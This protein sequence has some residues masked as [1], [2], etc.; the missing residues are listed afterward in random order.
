MHIKSHAVPTFIVATSLLVGFGSATS[1]LSA[2][3]TATRSAQSPGDKRGNHNLTFIPEKYLKAYQLQAHSIRHHG[4][5]WLKRSTGSECNPIYLSD[6]ASR[7]IL[8]YD[9][10]PPYQQIGSLTSSGGYG[11]G[12][13]AN[14][15]AIF[16]GNA[17]VD[18]I[19]EYAPCGA[20]VGLHLAGSGSGNAYGIAVDSYGTVYATEWP[21]NVI[22][23]F[24]GNGLSFRT[25]SDPNMGVPY[26][27]A[28][29]GSNNVYLSG[30]SVGSSQQQIDKC[31]PGVRLCSTFA[32]IPS[33][34]PGG[35][36]IDPNGNV[37]VN[38][39][40]GTIYTYSSSGTLLSSF[41]YNNGSNSF[42]YTAIALDPTATQ[43]WAANVNTCSSNPCG[44]AQMQSY[45]ATTGIVGP[46]GASTAEVNNAEPL[47]LAELSATPAPGQCVTPDLAQVGECHLAVMQTVIQHF[48]EIWTAV[49]VNDPPPPSRFAQVFLEGGLKVQDIDGQTKSIFSQELAAMQALRAVQM[50]V[51]PE[52]QSVLAQFKSGL[53]K[54]N[55]KPTGFTII[56]NY[57]NMWYE[58]NPPCAGF[59]SG[60]QAAMYIV[61]DGES[62]IYNAKWVEQQIKGQEEQF[63]RHSQRQYVI[64][65]DTIGGI[66]KTALAGDVVGAV[67]GAAGGAAVSW[68]TGAGVL[69]GAGVGAL[70]TAVT[71]SVY[72]AGMGLYHH[73]FG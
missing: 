26:E 47:G 66:A 61:Q 7:Q 13:A 64:P 56:L 20:A 68:W 34:F 3:P 71:S 30:W 2:T 72:E 35:V 62:T 73:F 67:A 27:I 65:D 50:Q 15:Y 18:G 25:S 8:V 23:V 14:Q 70:G 4:T 49:G 54:F 53:P 44:D 5:S 55:G 63:K 22:D 33:G 57:L 31:A 69:V 12:I 46:L 43:L 11:L 45:D 10:S 29:D 24:A 38:S 39:Q 41:N 17:S 36:A 9:N 32:T 51:S 28:I 59:Q 58:K 60:T 6:F 42:A 21:S 16:A 1:P 19:D 52:C 40:Y 48:V 37:I